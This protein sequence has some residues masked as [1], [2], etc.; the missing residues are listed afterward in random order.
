M[1]E[2]KTVDVLTAEDKSVLYEMLE[3]VS[4]LGD[5]A[6]SYILGIGEGISYMSDQFADLIQRSNADS[7]NKVAGAT[8]EAYLKSQGA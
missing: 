2:E 5:N 8:M 4:Q 7:K 6:R 3:G 1:T